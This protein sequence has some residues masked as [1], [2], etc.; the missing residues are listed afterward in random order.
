MAF[1]TLLVE[2]LKQYLKF[3]LYFAFL[4][5]KHI[6]YDL[7]GKKI[8]K[9]PEQYCHGRISFCRHEGNVMK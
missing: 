4:G 8:F 6:S 9:M 2:L 7:R 3:E 5:G 1:L